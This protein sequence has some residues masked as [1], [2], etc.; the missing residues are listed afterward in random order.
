M[1]LLT[2]K[3][4]PPA[5]HSRHPHCVAQ[6]LSA[7][8]YVVTLN[9]VACVFQ[10]IGLRGFFFVYLFVLSN[11]ESFSRNGNGKQECGL[12][13]YAKT[14]WFVEHKRINRQHLSG[15]AESSG[16][17]QALVRKPRFRG[18]YVDVEYLTDDGL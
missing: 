11:K 2:S 18:Q 10:T 5:G 12:P 4:R 15:E 17:S 7:Q 16:E 14:K 3:R 6:V 8:H 1:S 9:Q 13:S